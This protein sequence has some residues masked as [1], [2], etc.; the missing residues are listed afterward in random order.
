V[1]KDDQR[2]ELR[3]R[4]SG[5]HG[6]LRSCTQPVCCVI[7]DTLFLVSELGLVVLVELIEV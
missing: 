3:G 6:C 4:R 7:S 5:R 1:L 2:S